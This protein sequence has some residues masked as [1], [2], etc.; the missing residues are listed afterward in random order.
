MARPI[1][2]STISKDKDR[3]SIFLRPMKCSIRGNQR[4]KKKV[5]NIK[6]YLKNQTVQLVLNC[7]LSER[8]REG[9]KNNVK[10]ISIYLSLG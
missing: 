10:N 4:I 1:R 6:N 3:S 2:P 9:K 7:L 8:E 5:N